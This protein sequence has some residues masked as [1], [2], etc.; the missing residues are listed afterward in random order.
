[1]GLQVGVQ[2]LDRCFSTLQLVNFTSEDLIV[3]VQRVLGRFLVKF[4]PQKPF[5][6]APRAYLRFLGVTLEAYPAVVGV[7]VF[8]L[9]EITFEIQFRFALF[10]DQV[11]ARFLTFKE[12]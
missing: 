3:F 2:P 4:L 9:A 11:V 10:Q 1:M 12:A 6:V 5:A 8:G 7:T